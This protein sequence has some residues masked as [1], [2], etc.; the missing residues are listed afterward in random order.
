MDNHLNLH[1]ILQEAVIEVPNFAFISIFFFFFPLF[2]LLSI[3]YNR[4]QINQ[5]GIQM[6]KSEASDSAQ[7]NARICEKDKQ[8]DKK[9]LQNWS[10]CRPEN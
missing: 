7:T 8:D 4:F 2:V 10:W 1:T 5:D 3:W 6:R 9:S